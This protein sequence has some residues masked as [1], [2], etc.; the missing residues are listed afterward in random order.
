LPLEF[1]I[2]TDPVVSCGVVKNSEPQINFGPVTP[3]QSF[4]VV[5]L[6]EMANQAAAQICMN[7]GKVV[8]VGHM[9]HCLCGDCCERKRR[10][11]RVRIYRFEG[12]DGYGPYNGSNRELAAKLS[13]GSN[14]AH[15]TPFWDG[16]DSEGSFTPWF[17]G[18]ATMRTMKKWFT[19][20][21]VYWMDL[22]EVKLV[23]Y[24]V[25]NAFVQRGK[26]QAIFVKAEAQLLGEVDV[27]AYI[28]QRER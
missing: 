10:S 22:Y 18:F 11:R 23:Q 12:S 20:E 7:K 13:Q 21:D 5:K 28:D 27:N 6:M 17:C 15:P 4:Y 9:P 26:F 2:S 3:S 19:P 1:G 16:L 25:P 14:Y 8:S 24:S